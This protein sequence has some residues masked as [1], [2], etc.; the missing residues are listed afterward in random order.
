MSDFSLW[1]PDVANVEKNKYNSRILC[2]SW[3]PD[4]QC[5]AFGTFNGVVSVRDKK[6]IEKVIF[7][8]PND[9]ILYICIK[10]KYK[11][12]N[13]TSSKSQEKHLYGV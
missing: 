2:S 1:T 8:S 13:I 12:Y 6:L 7:I 5:L 3:T 4:G 10:F 9:N 11:Y